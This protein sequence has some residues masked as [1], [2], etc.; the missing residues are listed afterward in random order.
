M[1][2]IWWLS[3]LKRASRGRGSKKS[4]SCLLCACQPQWLRAIFCPKIRDDF[5][6]CALQ[7]KKVRSALR[8]SF[9][10]EG[11]KEVEQSYSPCFFLRSVQ[12][13]GK[14][15][16]PP[17]EN[18]RTPA[19]L[20]AAWLSHLFLSVPAVHCSLC[21]IDCLSIYCL[22]AVFQ[23]VKEMDYKN[24][25]SYFVLYCYHHLVSSTIYIFFAHCIKT[26][27]TTKTTNKKGCRCKDTKYTLKASSHWL[28][29]LA[30]A[31]WNVWMCVL[32]YSF[33][34]L[35][36]SETNSSGCSSILAQPSHACPLNDE[37][38]PTVLH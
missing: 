30:I 12:Q 22:L 13:A 6:A 19:P 33:K 27:T 7:K 17:G 9:L 14:T 35:V 24:I 34:F 11:G 38:G 18:R 10:K 28:P 15:S 5:I 25:S 31:F 20:A 36:S 23:E 3:C 21:S 2:T 26:T 29:K 32:S 1:T 4:H 16:K 8:L 37:L